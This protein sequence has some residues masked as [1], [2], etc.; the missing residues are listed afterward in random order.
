MARVVHFVVNRRTLG[1]VQ[2]LQARLTMTEFVM[3]CSEEALEP[4][5]MDT[6]VIEIDDDDDDPIF[7]SEVLWVD[8]SPQKS[9]PSLVR[10]CTRPNC[11][12]RKCAPPASVR[13]GDACVLPASNAKAPSTA[14]PD[15]GHTSIPQSGLQT[16]TLS[17]TG[18]APESR[19]PQLVISNNQISNSGLIT[20]LVPRDL[21]GTSFTL[22]PAGYPMLQQGAVLNLPSKQSPSQPKQPA[23]QLMNTIPQPTAQSSLAIPQPTTQSSLAIPQPNA[24]SSLAIPQ[25]TAQ[26]SLAIPQPTAQ[27]SIITLHKATEL[28]FFAPLGT[29]YPAGTFFTL[30]PAGY[31]MLQQ[32]DVLNLPSAQPSVVPQKWFVQSGPGTLQCTQT[33]ALTIRLKLLCPQSQQATPT[34]QVTREMCSPG[35]ATPD[36]EKRDSRPQPMNSDFKRQMCQLETTCPDDTL[37]LKPTGNKCPSCNFLF[38]SP[39]LLRRHMKECCFHLINSVFPCT[40]RTPASQNRI[41][42]QGKLVMP[43][44]EFYYGNHSGNRMV[45]EKPK[46]GI[47]FTCPSCFRVL[48]NNIGFMNHMR[49]HL[50]LLWQSRESQ[51]SHTAC[52]HCY[53][54]Y[55]TPCRLHL[56][57]ER[58][59]TQY[60]STTTCKICE[61][62]FETELIL[63]EH[64][65]DTHKPGEMPYVCQICNYRSSFFSEVENHFRSEHENTKQL[66]C[67]FCLKVQESGPVYGKH[68]M[69]H[70]DKEIYQCEKCRL[71]FLSNVER[72]AH[73]ALFHRTFKKPKILKGLPL[74]TEVVIRTSV[75]ATPHSDALMSK[76]SPLSANARP[77]RDPP[78]PPPEH[79]SPHPLRKGH[80]A[81]WSLSYPLGEHTCVECSAKIRDFSDHFMAV[82]F[83]DECGYRSSCFKSLQDHKI[84][85]HGALPRDGLRK[86]PMKSQ[87]VLRG[88]TSL[89]CLNCDFVTGPSNGNL[90]TKH[91]LDRPY[92]T[93][94]VIGE[95]GPCDQIQIKSEPEFF[96]GEQVDYSKNIKSENLSEDLSIS[97]ALMDAVFGDPGAENSTESGDGETDR[98][99]IKEEQAW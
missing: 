75:S 49:H 69:K 33:G 11:A 73:D 14:Q 67:P 57:T 99:K 34:S 30:L 20:P 93:C 32:G 18:P 63:L 56:H 59:H 86:K 58:A 74:G 35:A 96:T 87:G 88:I 31:P 43:V 22:L 84:R 98:M 27:S 13:G 46:T 54:R 52:Q 92:H 28:R 5:Q 41:Y 19:S 81:P 85:L 24:Q 76:S 68:Y 9:G 1:F 53:R 55:S 66:L 80:K 10:M 47:P 72:V 6:E 83:C 51:D 8:D 12:G 38:S 45:A 17:S 70:Q 91:L 29:D 94:R 61:L 89:E 26:S 95:K 79:P 4:W 42:D 48:K 40:R 65:R 82:M 44:N 37:E 50:E 39:R 21:A 7:V 64:M 62:A 90:M 23:P 78:C 3:V 77:P 2:L 16:V 71:N 15:S 60:E 25:P 36:P 97:P